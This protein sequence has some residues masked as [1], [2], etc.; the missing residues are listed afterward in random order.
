MNVDVLVE[1]I[2]DDLY[3]ATASG[4]FPLTAEGR[5]PHDAIQ[6][7]RER[8]ARLLEAGA[9]VTTIDIPIESSKFVQWIGWMK[10]DPMQQEWLAAIAENRRLADIE[11]GIV[12]EPAEIEAGVG[13]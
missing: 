12:R 1:P 5:S 11:E 9:M 8:I 2:H 13:A 7:L 3:R 4:P 6:T 10:D